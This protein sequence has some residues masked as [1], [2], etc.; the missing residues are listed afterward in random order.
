MREG[1]ERGVREAQG[2]RRSEGRREGRRRREAYEGAPPPGLVC[3][4]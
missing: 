4:N 3:I 2:V 1:E